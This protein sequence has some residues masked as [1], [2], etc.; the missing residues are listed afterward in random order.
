MV[1]EKNAFEN[2]FSLQ[3]STPDFTL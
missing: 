2:C 3:V 1:S